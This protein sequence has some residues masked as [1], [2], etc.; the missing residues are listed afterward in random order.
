MDTNPLTNTST[1]EKYEEVDDFDSFKM[2]ELSVG[3]SLFIDK[4]M[5]EFSVGISIFIEREGLNI[6][7]HDY[8]IAVWL[9][10]KYV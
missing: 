9:W 8:A 2:P 6:I 5:P 7:V 3:V 1:E 4:K 10:V